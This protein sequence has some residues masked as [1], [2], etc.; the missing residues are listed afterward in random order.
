MNKLRGELAIAEKQIRQRDDFLS[1]LSGE[2]VQLQSTVQAL[3]KSV[4]KQKLAEDNLRLREQ[5]SRM[6]LQH[7]DLL[8]HLS[9]VQQQFDAVRDELIVQRRERN[10]LSIQ[11]DELQTERKATLQELE[12]LKA[13]LNN[14][15]N[16]LQVERTE[17]AQTKIKAED[18]LDEMER[19]TQL[20]EYLQ[21][22]VRDQQNLLDN[23][24]RET[25]ELAALLE[26]THASQT[27]SDFVQGLRDTIHKLEVKTQKYETLVQRY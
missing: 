20:A 9:Q 26:S 17:H 8:A 19:I 3:L 24:S 21:R 10:S 2:K 13:A 16:V 7:S 6:E 4:D 11:C 27:T 12:F 23:K 25:H 22:Q 1:Q 15:R 14:S 18:L 5:G